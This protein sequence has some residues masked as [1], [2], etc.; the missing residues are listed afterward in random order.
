MV[1]GWRHWRS[2]NPDRADNNSVRSV[3]PR[4]GGLSGSIGS[5]A[6]TELA[7]DGRVRCHGDVVALADQELCDVPQISCYQDRSL[8]AY[9]C[10]G[11]QVFWKWLLGTRRTDRST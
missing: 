9:L 1:S 8:G 10:M 11:P 5:L 2:D 3:Q 6:T 7:D 4:I